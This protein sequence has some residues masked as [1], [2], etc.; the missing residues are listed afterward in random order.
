MIRAILVVLGAVATSL[1]TGAATAADG[2]AVWD[3]TCAGCHA[4]MAP[5]TGDKAAWAPLIKRGAEDLTASTL[6]GKGAMPPKGGAK[7]EEDVRASIDY[8]ISQM[9]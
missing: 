6:K 4:V 8:I 9:K 3:K 1:A 2:K 7:S 5:K